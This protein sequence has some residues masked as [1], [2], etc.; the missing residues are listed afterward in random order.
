MLRARVDRTLEK[1]RLGGLPAAPEAKPLI[2]G[3]DGNLCSGC[4][5][6]IEPADQLYSVRVVAPYRFHD[7]CYNAWATFKPAV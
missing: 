6:T 5:E 2:E 4:G 1:I 7:V 3:G